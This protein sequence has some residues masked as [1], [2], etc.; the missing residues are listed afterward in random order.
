MQPSNHPAS[1]DQS[2]QRPDG[3]KV[4]Q[5]PQLT[6]IE[7]SDTEGGTFTTTFEGGT[8]KLVS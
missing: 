5:T 8:G 7:L 1:T 6:K 2:G 3:K 4:W